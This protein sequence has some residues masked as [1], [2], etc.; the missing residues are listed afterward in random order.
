MKSAAHTTPRWRIQLITFARI[1]CLGGAVALNGCAGQS[2]SVPPKEPK[3]VLD[4][5]AGRRAFADVIVVLRS[6]RCINCHQADDRP[7]QTDSGRMH[8]P[9][10]QRGADD[11]GENG[12]RCISCHQPENQPNGIPGAP[13]WSLAPASM[14][15]AGLDDHALAEQ[16]RD[17][18]RNGHRTSEQL[19]GHISFD[20]LVLWAWEPGGDRTSPPL[21]HDQFVQRFKDWLTAGAPSPTPDGKT[22]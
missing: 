4:R 6:P 11:H 13:N 21:T 14:A 10:V 18:A 5:D 7:R 9:P 12:G 8:F 17:P 3:A 20:Q 1:A 15:W 22:L 19:I 16:L 2:A